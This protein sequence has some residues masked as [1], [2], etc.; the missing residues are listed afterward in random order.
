MYSVYS[1]MQLI[2]TLYQCESGT[3]QV[4]IYIVSFIIH[5]KIIKLKLQYPHPV[6]R[7]RADVIRQKSLGRVS[8]QKGGVSPLGGSSLHASYVLFFLLDDRHQEA[9]ACCNLRRR[10]QARRKSSNKMKGVQLTRCAI[11]PP[12]QPSPAY[13]DRKRKL[14][15]PVLIFDKQCDYTDRN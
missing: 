6:A 11:Q 3:R 13:S 10:E 9:S 15:Q 8:F 4:F 12:E 14:A 5:L 1:F 7:S 2:L